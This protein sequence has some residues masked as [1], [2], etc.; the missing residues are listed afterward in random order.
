[1]CFLVLMV[2]LKKGKVTF[3]VIGKNDH[4]VNIGFTYSFSN[5]RIRCNVFSP[6]EEHFTHFVLMSQFRLPVPC[7]GLFLVFVQIV[8][9]CK[10]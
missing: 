10:S 4:I 1:M 6:V 3:S 7:M 5:F 9:S 2:R 8:F